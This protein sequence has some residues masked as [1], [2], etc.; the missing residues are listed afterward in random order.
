MGGETATN[1]DFSHVLGDKLPLFIAVVVIL[2]FLLLAA[3]FRSLLIPLTA[4][5]LNLLS[6][7][8]AL[9][10]VNAVFNWGWGASLLGLTGTGPSMPSSPS[11][12]SRSCS[13]SP[14]TTRYS[15]SAGCRKNGGA[16]IPVSS[17]RRHRAGSRNHLAVT[18]GQ[19]KS[20]RIIIAAAGIMILVFGSFL[21]GGHRLLQEFGFGLA[22]S[23]LVDA[24]VIRSLLLRPRSCTSSAR[25]TGPCRSGSVELCLTSTSKPRVRAARKSTPP[26]SVHRPGSAK[27]GPAW[28]SATT[29][30]RPE[31]HENDHRYRSHR[32]TG[33]EGDART[34]STNPTN[35]LVAAVRS[36]EKGSN[37]AALGVTI[38]HCDY[39]K[40]ETI[41]S[42]FVDADRVLLISSNDFARSG[43]QHTAVIDAARD[44]GV[45]LLAYTSLAHADTS[46]L[47]VAAPHKYTEFIIRESGLPF[48]VLRNN[49]YTEH[50]A[51]AIRQ[52]VGSD[53]LVGSAG[54]GRIASA[55]RA[56]YAA[57]A[58]VLV[59]EG[60]ENKTYEL[61][62]R[63]RG[64]WKTSRPAH[65][66]YRQ[67]HRIPTPL[68]DD[69]FE[70][71]V[72]S[73]I[74]APIAE[75]F[76]DTYEGI[77][78]GELADTTADL[79]RLIG[80]PGTSLTQTIADVLEAD[81]PAA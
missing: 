81:Q 1:I 32:T 49:L 38:R 65:R 67:D 80:R 71:L 50:F 53:T 34:A 52:A 27:I 18:L 56:D 9:G 44:A 5:V 57:A 47:R 45:E 6:V 36:P 59:G 51:L 55:T 30:H 48:T 13:G 43:D 25:P 77:A 72:S 26:S 17:S 54:A 28:S 14:W 12:C 7:G 29:S 10:A 37:L 4:A 70:F 24:L 73:G 41:A 15:P 68:W 8:A 58:Q 16:S 62:G 39:D 23:V 42:A 35:E 21:L 63:T 40:S 46:T 76:V 75:V 79:P 66:N 60:H 11:S 78:Y 69:H 31:R 3:V 61:S 22:F 20:S 33:H 2:A 64:L 19:A 74:P